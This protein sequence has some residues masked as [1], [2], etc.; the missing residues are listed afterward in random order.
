MTKWICILLLASTA[1]YSQMGARSFIPFKVKSELV[2]KESEVK[3]DLPTDQIGT[4]KANSSGV[5]KVLVKNVTDSVVTKPFDVSS[6]ETFGLYGIGNTNTETF[7]NINASGKLSGYV[8]PLKMTIKNVPNYVDISFSFNVN[9]SNTDSLAVKTIVFPDVGDNSFSTTLV[10][11]WVFGQDRDFYFVAPF[12]EFANKS[13]KGRNENENRSFYTLNS[14]VGISFQYL[15]VDANEDK[16]SLSVS[17]YI[18][19]VNVPE[20]GK[21]DYRYLLTGD[22]NSTLMDNIKSAGV[23]VTFQ[24]NYFQIFADFR[25]VHGNKSELPVKGFGG[26][27]PNI[28]VVFNAEIFQR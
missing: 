13:I 1:G 3:I 21:K 14:S 25:D 5:I 19:W 27:H 12:Y 17:P 18:A 15:F 9:A 11:N 10:W 4:D 2:R 7:Q 23:K 24:Y 6:M 26:F 8:R 22:E 28:G 16:I 20:P